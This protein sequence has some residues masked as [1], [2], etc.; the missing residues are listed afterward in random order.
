MFTMPAGL[1]SADFPTADLTLADLILAAFTTPCN[2]TSADFSIADLTFANLTAVKA[3]SIF[4]SSFLSNLH[5]PLV[6][7]GAFC[8]T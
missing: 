7:E 8:L 1:I 2:F 5:D 3:E 6:I 4:F